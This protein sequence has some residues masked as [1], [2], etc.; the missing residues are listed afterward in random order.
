ML[1][2]PVP[3]SEVLEVSTEVGSVAVPVRV[4]PSVNVI[5]I[6]PLSV[7]SLMAAV[8]VNVPFPMFVRVTGPE[9]VMSVLVTI[10]DPLDTVRV[11]LIVAA[12]RAAA[13][14]IAYAISK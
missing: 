1:T 11:V 2:M 5:V 10:P 6:G 13:E 8:A 3:E 12:S 7:V 9:I 14:R 4:S